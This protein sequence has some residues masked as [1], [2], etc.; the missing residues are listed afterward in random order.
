MRIKG[1]IDI[2]VNPR[3]PEDVRENLNPTDEYFSIKTRQNLDIRQNG[4]AIDE[5]IRMMDRAGIERSLL[6]ASRCGDERWKD[7]LH[8]P[9]ERVAE[10]CAKHPDRLS[11]VAGIDPAMGMRQ[12]REL[13]HAVK[14][15]GFVSAHF[16]PHWFDMTADHAY[17]FPIYSKC[18]ELDIPIM[19]HVGHNLVYTRDRRL[20]SV[21]KPIQFDRI[22]I[23]F[24]ELKLVGIHLG[25]PWV[26]EM[27]SMC[28]KHE[29]VYMAGDAYAP[30]HWP[31]QVVHFANSYG[32][33]KFMFATDW[34]VIDVKRAVDDCMDANYR[35]ESFRKIMR[36]N[37]IKVFKL[38][39]QGL[40]TQPAEWA[41]QVG[42]KLAD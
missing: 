21:A 12:V 17:M 32:K 29:N 14:E 16:Y 2:V 22:S 37:A 34:P 11:G 6:V 28:W 15:Y 41:A 18:I 27:I 26:D 20:P 39:D 9:Y 7:S 13:E 19:I 8:Y 33:D 40:A 3:T 35:D 42:A 31:A 25:V 23:L 38:P 10:L 36:D 1:A 24:P 4:V 30:K 5:Y